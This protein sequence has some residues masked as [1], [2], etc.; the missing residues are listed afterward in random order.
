MS[1]KHYLPNRMT[2]YGPV[3]EISASVH[4]R[5][6]S[7]ELL[8]VNVKSSGNTLVQFVLH[9]IL[10]TRKQKI[11]NKKECDEAQTQSDIN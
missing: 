7:Y 3:A 10:I 6:R 5:R 11:G 2:A 8:W 4:C 1:G 9:A